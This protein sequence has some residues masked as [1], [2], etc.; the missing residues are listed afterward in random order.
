M[1]YLIGIFSLDLIGLL[2]VGAST[3]DAIVK[4]GAVTVSTN[5]H[6]EWNVAF[7]AQKTWK[8]DPSLMATSW[9]RWPSLVD[10]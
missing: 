10:F 8:D 9:R 4:S 6:A 7:A 5:A 2:S 3:S 1:R